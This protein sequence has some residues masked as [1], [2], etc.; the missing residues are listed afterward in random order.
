MM[1]LPEAPLSPPLP[2]TT[3]R[4]HHVHA[5][6]L[7]GFGKAV[8][9]LLGHL[10]LRPAVGRHLF[11]GGDGLG[12]TGAGDSFGLRLGQGADLG[13]LLQGALVFGLTLV[14]LDG[15]AQFGLGDVA[16]LFGA[17]LRFAQF[18]FLAGRSLLAVHRSRS[19]RRRSAVNAAG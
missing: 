8:H 2:P 18:A 5:R 13:G 14:G 15:D 10:V 1:L 17:G 3:T 11:F 19:V 16:L 12:N 9:H 7:D 6:L 4:G